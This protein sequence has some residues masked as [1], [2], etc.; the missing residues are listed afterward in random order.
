MG[1]GARAAAVALVAVVGACG[2]SGTAPSTT[3]LA[4]SWRAT[5]VEYV[6]LTNQS[7]KVELVSSGA[8]YTL[9]L[10]AGG[11][12]TLT[13]SHP[14]D[15]PIS[16]AGRYEASVDVLSLTYTSGALGEAQFDMTLSG[17]TLTLSGGHAPYDVNGDDLDEEALLNLVLARQ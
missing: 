12:F 17:N 3:E 6:N 2:K 5:K 13:G 11:T 9:V 10:T 7:Q 14:G 4:G 8:V 1:S 16:L 15:D